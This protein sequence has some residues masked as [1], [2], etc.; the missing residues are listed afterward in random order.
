MTFWKSGSCSTRFWAGNYSDLRLHH[1]GNMVLKMQRLRAPPRLR[2]AA[3]HLRQDVAFIPAH[4]QRPVGRG[5][6]GHPSHH[7]SDFEMEVYFNWTVEQD[8]F[9]EATH[10]ADS[11]EVGQKHA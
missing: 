1:E 5:V 9:G 6:Y 7:E 11:A 10:S 4:F 3:S 2:A 8:P